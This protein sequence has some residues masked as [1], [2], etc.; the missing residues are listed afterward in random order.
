P[1]HASTCAYA[2]RVSRERLQPTMAPRLR[3]KRREHFLR[4][5]SPAPRAAARSNP[6]ASP[7][8]PVTNAHVPCTKLF[9]FSNSPAWRSQKCS[10][11][12]RQVALRSLLWKNRSTEHLPR[13]ESLR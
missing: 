10:Q 1:F 2:A 5:S 6:L 4:H 11:E 12:G 3:G 9:P 7:N 8:R 13:H